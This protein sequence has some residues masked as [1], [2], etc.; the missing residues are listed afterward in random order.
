[1]GGTTLSFPTK[2]FYVNVMSVSYKRN[3]FNRQFIAQT[4][5]FKIPN[6]ATKFWQQ[7]SIVLNFIDFIVM[8]FSRTV[9]ADIYPTFNFEKKKMHLWYKIRE[10][11]MKTKFVVCHPIC[12]FLIGHPHIVTQIKYKFYTKNSTSKLM[13]TLL[14][15]AIY[16]RV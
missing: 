10:V 15:P 2:I 1:M 5:F 14:I 9:A 12:L 13:S 4:I 6:I 11:M 16:H 7:K 8:Y 3:A